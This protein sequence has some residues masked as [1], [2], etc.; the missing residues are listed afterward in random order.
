[1]KSTNTLSH[2][3]IE[4]STD[5]YIIKVALNDGTVLYPAYISSNDINLKEKL[6]EAS[7]LFSSRYRETGTVE[8]IVDD[9]ISST[10]NIE[11]W[12]SIKKEIIKNESDTKVDKLLKYLSE[13]NVST[14]FI[15]TMKEDLDYEKNEKL[16]R[17]YLEVSNFSESEK[18]KTVEALELAI[19][20]HRGQVQKRKKDKEGLDNIPYSNHPIQVAIIALRDLKMSAEEVQ[21]ALLHDVIEDVEELEQDWNTLSIRKVKS[22]FS[23]NTISIVDDCSRAPDVSRDDF[24]VAIKGLTWPSKIIKCL[25]RLHNL[26]RAFSITDASYIERYIAETKEVYLPAFENMDELSPVKNL[27]YD[28]LSELEKYY[29]RIK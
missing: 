1:M 26:I 10:Q 13:L 5:Q 6:I 16:F 23:S 12:D 20:A 17:T 2:E 21:A 11:S 24:M 14:W 4:T 7:K 25:D 3:S 27:F 15:D 9:N 29:E 18:V 28:V 22:E 8:T 19:E